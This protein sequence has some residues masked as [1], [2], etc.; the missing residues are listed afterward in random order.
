MLNMTSEGVQCI[1]RKTILESFQTLILVLMFLV[2]LLWYSTFTFVRVCKISPYNSAGPYLPYL[3]HYMPSNDPL[4]YVQLL[5]RWAIQ[6]VWNCLP[7]EGSICLPISP[8]PKSKMFIKFLNLDQDKACENRKER[9][10]M[11][12][13]R[14]GRLWQHIYVCISNVCIKNGTQFMVGTLIES[15]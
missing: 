5:G 11:K 15:L 8:I 13:C 1:R 9:W 10:T 14:A 2:C 6:W 4:H 3:S 12:T 7:Q